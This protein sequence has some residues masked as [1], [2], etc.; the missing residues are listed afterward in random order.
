MKLR[1]ET[2]AVNAGIKVGAVY[3]QSAA[4]HSIGRG[5]HARAENRP[6]AMLTMVSGQFSVF[7]TSGAMLDADH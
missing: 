2:R 5:V 7:D 1:L 3:L 4:A 6:L